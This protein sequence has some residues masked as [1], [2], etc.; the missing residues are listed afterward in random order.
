MANRGTHHAQSDLD[1]AS[2]SKLNRKHHGLF[3][4][5]ESEKSA[6]GVGHHVRLFGGELEIDELLDSGEV[7]ADKGA[8]VDKQSRSAVHVESNAVR[9]IGFDGLFRLRR[10]QACLE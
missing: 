5:I 9:M 1:C 10:R 8:A 2:E 6:D 3:G 7:P 4:E